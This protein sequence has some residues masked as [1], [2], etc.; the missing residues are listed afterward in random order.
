M[1]FCNPNL[2]PQNRLL[3]KTGW[4]KRKPFNALFE[5]NIAAT[6]LFL[7]LLLLLSILVKE[8]LKF[9]PDHCH[10]QTTASIIR[11][12]VGEL[13]FVAM[14]TWELIL[15]GQSSLIIM[16][17]QCDTAAVVDDEKFKQIVPH[18]LDTFSLPICC[19]PTPTTSS[20]RREWDWEARMHC[21]C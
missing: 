20:M 18:V 1:V 14:T 3:P 5:W 2:K 19:C 7:S 11:K 16:V 9:S 17:M 8:G 21:W 4:K 6:T 12:G 10:G 13:L 15:W